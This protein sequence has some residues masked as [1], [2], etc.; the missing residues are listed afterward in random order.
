MI[1]DLSGTLEKKKMRVLSELA[2][3]E[4]GIL[5]ALDRSSGNR[6]W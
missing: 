2:V 4:R 5:V 1:T 3:G 6:L